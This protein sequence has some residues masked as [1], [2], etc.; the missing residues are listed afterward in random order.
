MLLPE[1]LP[2]VII[3]YANRFKKR[4]LFFYLTDVIGP[5]DAGYKKAFGDIAFKALHDAQH[6]FGDI[7]KRGVQCVVA[8]VACL[9]TVLLLG[10]H[11]LLAWVVCAND[12]YVIAFSCRN[13]LYSCGKLV[14]GEIGFCNMVHHFVCA[15]LWYIVY[16]SNH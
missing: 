16:E 15:C 4:R 12:L 8:A 13:V 1:K 3:I 5:F 2:I 9:Y 11:L 10:V 14:D 7:R 6:F